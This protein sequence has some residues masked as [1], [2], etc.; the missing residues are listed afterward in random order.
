MNCRATQLAR[1]Q[2][3]G[4]ELC[5]NGGFRFTNIES[6]YFDFVFD[7]PLGNE[8]L[9][10]KFNNCTE[11][12]VLKVPVKSTKTVVHATNEKAEVY[13]RMFFGVHNN[14]VY[15]VEY[16][17]PIANYFYVNFVNYSIHSIYNLINYIV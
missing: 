6:E 13:F 2:F 16:E 9:D 10:I 7:C 1:I 8:L 17:E 11:I 15:V 14:L 5:G 3:A 4:N 12:N